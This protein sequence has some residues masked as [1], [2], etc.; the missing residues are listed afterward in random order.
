MT[1]I[2]RK[3][4]C[5]RDYHKTLGIKLEKRLEDV[6]TG[7]YGNTTVFAT[8]PKTIVAVTAFLLDYADKRTKWEQGGIAQKKA[9]EKIVSEGRIMMDDFADYVD[10]IADGDITVIRMAGFNPSFDT[11]LLPK[12]GINRIDNITLKR[13]EDA[14]GK[15]IS[16]N[17]RLPKGTTVIGILCEGVP[18]TDE[19]EI[20]SEGN[21]FIPGTFTANV[22]VN[23]TKQNK[24]YWINLKNGVT[25][26]VYHIAVSSKG[27]SLISIAV[28]CQC[29]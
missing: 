5:K 24:K 21:I 11:A 28:S 1:V 6:K 23:M 8:P 27:V 10:E 22:R 26:Y 2:I 14:P 16:E 25:Y 15:L 7:V 9:Y 3:S 29:I 19:F 4:Y 13:V 18:L 20:D 12:P 17:G